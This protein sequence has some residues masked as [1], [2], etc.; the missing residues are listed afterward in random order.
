MKPYEQLSSRSGIIC[1]SCIIV[2]ALAFASV[3]IFPDNSP[4]WLRRVFGVSVIGGYIGALGSGVI[5][6]AAAIFGRKKSSSQ[7]DDKHEDNVA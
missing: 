2:S 1:S 3:W 5:C 7:I 4:E 6:I